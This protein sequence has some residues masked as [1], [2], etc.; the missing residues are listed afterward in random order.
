MPLRET[1]AALR[2]VSS[3]SCILHTQVAP[4]CSCA[5]TGGELAQSSPES[6]RN[7]SVDRLVQ[8]AASS[9]RVPASCWPVYTRPWTALVGAQLCL[10]NGLLTAGL[11]REPSARKHTTPAKEGGVL[12]ASACHC[13]AP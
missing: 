11:E 13:W 7:V 8:V 2:H 3:A 1:Q 9:N 4:V 6:T 5:G 12:Q 10:R